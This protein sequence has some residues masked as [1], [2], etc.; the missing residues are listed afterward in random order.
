MEFQNKVAV[1]TGG[2]TGIGR[3][4]TL[5]LLRGGAT[6]VVAGRVGSV[7][8]GAMSPL[9]RM[10]ACAAGSVRVLRNRAAAAGAKAG[11]AVPAENDDR[12]C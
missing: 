11:L 7:A 5:A 12:D 10:W 1:V 9:A 2:A 3:A 8:A 4:T 6:V